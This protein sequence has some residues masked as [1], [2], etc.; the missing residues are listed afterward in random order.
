MNYKTAKAKFEQGCKTRDGRV[1]LNRNTYLERLN[2]KTFG[3]RLHNTVIV[4]ITPH[5]IE[6]DSGGWH[7]MTTRS[8]MD[9]F[10]PARVF[11]YRQGWAIFPTVKVDCYCVQDADQEWPS[12][13]VRGERAI[14]KRRVFTG[15]YE[16]PDG[17]ESTRGDFDARAIYEWRMCETCQGTGRRMGQDWDSGGFPYFDG[18]RI[19]P[20]GSGL[21]KTQPR[22]PKDWQPVVTESGFSGRT[23]FSMN[24]G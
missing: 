4:T 18:I 3:V 17:S 22:K 10:S 13:A 14:G 24:R 19:K 20:D 8:R 2:D 5:W 23:T 12:V 7:T 21:M 1:K 11:S 16:L 9:A 15:L 6:L